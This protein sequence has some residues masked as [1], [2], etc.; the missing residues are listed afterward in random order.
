MPHDLL[1]GCAKS[2]PSGPMA[3]G[4]LTAVV[5]LA[6]FIA[7]LPAVA[8]ADAGAV[9]A[10]K[11]GDHWQ[12]TVF[13]DPTP[14]R[15][16]PIDV[17]VFV[18]DAGTGQPILDSLIDIEVTPRGRSS[19]EMR[20][21]A[22]SAAASNKLFQA[23]NFNLPAAG[24]WDFTVTIRRP[25]DNIDLHFELEAADSLPTWRTLWPWFCWPFFV[26][27]LFAVSRWCR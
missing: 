9:R 25:T 26:V 27:A 18:Q 14:L 21:T 16:G 22:T 11:R 24:W 5:C 15:A 7:I 17:S 2:A 6:A 13:T 23:A 12:V 1:Q 4:T 19:E 8:I 20:L 3:G 10:S